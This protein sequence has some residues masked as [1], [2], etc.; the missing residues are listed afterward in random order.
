MVVE[1]ASPAASVTALGSIAACLRTLL[2]PQGTLK[3]AEAT[4]RDGMLLTGDALTILDRL[5][6]SHP[7]GTLLVEACEGMASSQGCGITTL[8]CLT[9]ELA[10]EALSLQQQVSLEPHTAGTRRPAHARVLPCSP[11]AG[12]CSGLRD[13]CGAARAAVCCGVV[14]EARGY[15]SN[16]FSDAALRYIYMCR[17]V[18]DD[19]SLP[20]AELATAPPVQ[21]VQAAA[22]AAVQPAT[23]AAVPP[24]AMATSLP[25]AAAA[26]DPGEPSD[27][28]DHD[29]SPDPKYP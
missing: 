24:V 1:S 25:P 14:Q 15:P 3:F 22:T 17:S 9:G 8:I 16:T 7:A 28:D 2:G 21:T 29:T 10:K 6:V 12:R 5:E 18:S 4:S 23:E 27:D 11:K 20:L 19:L 13:A 26:S